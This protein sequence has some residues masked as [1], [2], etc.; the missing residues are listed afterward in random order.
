M[1]YVLLLSMLAHLVAARDVSATSCRR[2]YRQLPRWCDGG[3][4]CFPLTLYVSIKEDATS[5]QIRSLQLP[6]Q[7][8]SERLFHASGG[9][10]FIDKVTFRDRRTDGGLRFS[11]HFK[12]TPNG[13]TNIPMGPGHWWD[14]T[15]FHELGHLK[16]GL[17]DE[18]RYK[19]TCPRCVMALNSYRF[20]SHRTHRGHT[21]RRPACW[22]RL[23]QLF[24]GLPPYS[25]RPSTLGR[26][27]PAIQFV[28]H[29]SGR[30]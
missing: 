8:A 6:L 11:F 5:P 10:F 9:L 7:Q 13:G 22:T 14:R 29:N 24:P 18:Y 28:V 17:W 12:G 16:L 20:C 1:R 3:R 19:P 23:Q 25:K 4:I 26:H 21:T 27:A 15:I 30:R 2:P